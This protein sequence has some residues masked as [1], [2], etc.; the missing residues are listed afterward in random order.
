MKRFL[1][2]LIEEKGLTETAIE[3]VGASGVNFMTVETVIENILVAP[4][5]EQKAIKNMLV[6]ID[7]LNGDIMDFFKHLAKAI[8]I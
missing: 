8:A 4:K 7:F 2:T 3:V 5:S 1:N 6:K